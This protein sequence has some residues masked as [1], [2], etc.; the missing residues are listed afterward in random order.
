VPAIEGVFYGL[1]CAVLALVLQA[2]LRIGGRALKTRAAWVLACSAFVALFVFAVPYPALVFFAGAIGAFAPAKFGGGGPAEGDDAAPGLIDSVLAED[3]GRASRLARGARQAGLCALALWLL[4]VAAL[5]ILAPGTFADIGFFFSKMAVVTLGGAYAVLAYVAQDA[6]QT[7]HWL[8]PA[9]MVSGLGLAET[10]PGPLILV[11]Q[12][13]GFL[14]GARAPGLLHG[15]WG[16]LAASALT[17]WVIFLPS[18]VFVFF[19]APLVERFYA[20][21]VLRGA[22]AAITAC[23][24]GVIANLAAWFGLHVLFA[25]LVP[26]HLGW[27]VFERPVPQNLDPV[28]LLLAVLAG[29]CLFRLRWPVPATLALTALCGLVARLA[30]N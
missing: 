23:V 19:G 9:E 13:V 16:G 17:L 2:L 27:V 15:F 30:W 29:V 20:N 5:K 6:V 18:L 10:T 8:S 26:V 11:L 24:V 12:F 25:R 7:Y 21:T 1:S 4:P 3:P 28:A 22:L 14:A